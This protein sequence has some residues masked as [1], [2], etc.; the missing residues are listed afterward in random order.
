MLCDEKV[1]VAQ[2]IAEDADVICLH[3]VLS[4]TEGIVSGCRL[5]THT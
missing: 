5:F 2:G 3:K 4:V 1:F